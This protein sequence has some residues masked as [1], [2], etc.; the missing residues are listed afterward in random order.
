[1]VLGWPLLSFASSAA[2]N[3]SEPLENAFDY[4]RLRAW[5]RIY[6]DLASAAQLDSQVVFHMVAALGWGA[7]G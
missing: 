1:M 6:R 2:G 7:R 4:R 3:V 5:R